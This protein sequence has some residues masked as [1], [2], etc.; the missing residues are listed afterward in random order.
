[1]TEKITKRQQAVLGDGD[2]AGL[3]LQP[4]VQV[5]FKPGQQGLILRQFRA[6]VIPP[7]GRKGFG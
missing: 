2:Q 1:M 5:Y 4:L 6:D 3:E 7:A